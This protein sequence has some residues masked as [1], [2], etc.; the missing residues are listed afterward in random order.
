MNTMYKV[1]VKFKIRYWNLPDRIELQDGELKKFLDET[2]D[3]SS[4]KRG[5]KLIEA[6]GISDAH[7]GFA[8]EGQTEACWFLCFNK[9]LRTN[10]YLYY[11]I[12][13][14]SK[15]RWKNI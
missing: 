9:K 4:A 1:W 6:Q 13:V 8:H 15:W 3:L 10:L 14:G 5:E 12:F 2:K 11:I 7:E